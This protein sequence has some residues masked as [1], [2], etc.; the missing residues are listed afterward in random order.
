MVTP[1]SPSDDRAGC[2]KGDAVGLGFYSHSTGGLDE[3]CLCISATLATG[4]DAK[5][6]TMGGILGMLLGSGG[7]QQQPNEVMNVLQDVLARNGGVQ[8]VISRFT[9][10]GY[11]EHARSWVGGD[12]LPVTGNQINEVFTPEE[13][14]GWASRLGVD[15]DK[16]RIVLAEAIPEVVDHLTPSGQ[17][18]TENAT[19]ALSGLVGRLFAPR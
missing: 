18:P 11:G 9:S 13:I 8:G 5:G 1:K 2:T 6:A 12:P 16:M 4:L 17:V 10:A 15:P 3:R 14:Q 7:Q 19:A